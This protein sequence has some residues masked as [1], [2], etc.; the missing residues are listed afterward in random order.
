M[1]RKTQKAQRSFQIRPMDF[2]GVSLKLLE[3]QIP[4]LSEFSASMALMPK[5]WRSDYYTEPRI[6]ELAAK[7]RA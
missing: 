4:S 3:I 7:E 1:A 5:L 6:Q 2:G